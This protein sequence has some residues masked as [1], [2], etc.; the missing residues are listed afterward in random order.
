MVTGARLVEAELEALGD[1]KLYRVPF[2]CTVA[3]KGQKQVALLNKAN[4]PARIV[5]RGFAAPN[6]LEPQPLTVEVRMDNKAATGLGLPLPSGRIAVFEGAGS[7]GLLIGEGRMRDYAVG[8]EVKFTIGASSAVQLAAEATPASKDWSS[9]KLVL[10]NA[11]SQ[12]V[13]AE[14]D[15]AQ[16]ADADIRGAS[17]R[18]IRKDGKHVWL[19]TVPANDTATLTYQTRA[20]SR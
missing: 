3:A 10:T 12:A 1:L 5:Y 20:I 15:L 4:V 18:T 16:I 6:R 13:T 7:D 2:R 14:I 8:Q 17:S 9:S 19:V 11:N